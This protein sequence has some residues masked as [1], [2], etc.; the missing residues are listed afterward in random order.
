M[1]T[2]TKGRKIIWRLWLPEEI[3]VAIEVRCFNP[4]TGKPDYGARSQLVAELLRR[5]LAETSETE[6]SL[7]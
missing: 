6:S 1:G 4:A 3:A 5:Y 2:A 7:P